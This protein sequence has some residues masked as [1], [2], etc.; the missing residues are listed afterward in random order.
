[1]LI[2]PE[3]SATASALDHKGNAQRT[4][5]KYVSRNRSRY[6]EESEK[7]VWKS[8]VYNINKQEMF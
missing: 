8:S 4:P 6:R 7:N 3:R 2:V 1:M 5:Q